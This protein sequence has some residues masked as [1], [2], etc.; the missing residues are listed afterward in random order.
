MLTKFVAI[1]L[2][3]VIGL[4]PLAAVAQTE[5]LAQAAP[6]AAPA[7]TPAHAAGGGSHRRH[8]RHR[9]NQSRERARAG[10][11][12]L[13]QMRTAPAAAAAPKSLSIDARH[14]LGAGNMIALRCVAA[15]GF[16]SRMPCHDLADEALLKAMRRQPP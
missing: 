13:R 2:G 5:Q 16:R 6:A 7:A 8:L 9:S 14:G 3:A 1:G 10:A 11:E 15:Q 12:H 4:A